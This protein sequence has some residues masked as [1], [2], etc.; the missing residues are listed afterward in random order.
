MDKNMNRKVDCQK[1]R[2]KKSVLL[3]AFAI[4]GIIILTIALTF[5]FYS[6]RVD[7]TP[8]FSTQPSEGVGVGNTDSEASSSVLLENASIPAMR[9]V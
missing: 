8:H 5:I 7:D 6:P 2:V 1:R 4:A 9:K 3:T